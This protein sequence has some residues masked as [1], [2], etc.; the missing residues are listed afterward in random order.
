[1]SGILTREHVLSDE[2]SSLDESSEDDNM[3]GAY[4]SARPPPPTPREIDHWNYHVSLQQFGKDLQAAAKAVFPNGSSSRY[5]DVSVLILSWEDEDPQLP[6]SIEIEKLYAVFQHVYHFETEHWKIPNHNCHY[7]VTKKIMDF[8]APTDD[9][10]HHLKIVYYAGHARL[11]DTRSLAWTSFRNNKN[12][13][14]PI[15]KWSGIQTVLEEAPCDVLILLDCCASGV[16]N[17]CEGNGVNEVISACAYNAIANG[18]GPYS[19][20]SALVIELRRLSK[21]AVFSVGGAI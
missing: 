6:V 21:K 13:K 17:T 4:L 11:M 12:P 19:F 10:D 2:H 7:R 1:M 16:A 14:C 18:V 20:T 8:V 3:S 15:V 9:I 5:T